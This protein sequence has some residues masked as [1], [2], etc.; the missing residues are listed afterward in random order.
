[1]KIS[2]VIASGPGFAN[3]HHPSF[4]DR[5]N[6]AHTSVRRS[7][8]A[9]SS[10][11]GRQRKMKRISFL[12]AISLLGG[13]AGGPCN[14]PPILYPILI[15]LVIPAAIA[16]RVREHNRR[17]GLK[18][19][20]GGD[21]VERPFKMQG[22]MTAMELQLEEYFGFWSKNH[23]QTPGIGVRWSSAVVD[24]KTVH[25][26]VFKDRSS[27]KESCY[28]FDVTAVHIIEGEPNHQPPPIPG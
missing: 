19:I 2:L 5:D 8:G 3:P 24:G 20:S 28:Y 22:E 16:G 4:L 21:T 11:T 1:M 18:P 23:F 15:P 7:R 10:S 9:R 27:A 14:P 26:V 6:P 13:C 25:A 17:A 12:A